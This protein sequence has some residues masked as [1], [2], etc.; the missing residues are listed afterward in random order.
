MERHV[1]K[2]NI[3]AMMIQEEKCFRCGKTILV[4]DLETQEVYCSKCGTVIHEKVNESRPERIFTTSPIDKSRDK[5]SLAR[6][7]RGLATVI[8]QFDKDYAGVLLSDSMKSTLK[9]LRKWDSQNRNRTTN[10]RNLQQ[11]SQNC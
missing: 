7:D 10:E 11:A 9:Q 8:N 1:E 2:Q 5:I 6:H 4:T 3:I